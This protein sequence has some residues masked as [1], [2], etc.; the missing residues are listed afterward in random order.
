MEESTD[1]EWRPISG[2]A[3][4]Y[5]VSDLGRVRSL[6]RKYIR[7]GVRAMA[8]D[9]AGYLSLLLY[10]DNSVPRMMLVHR[11]VALAFIGPCP[12]GQQV[13]HRDGNRLNP[14][15][16]NLMYGT[17]AENTFDSIGHGTHANAAKTHCAQ[18][19]EFTEENIY[20]SPGHPTVRTCRTCSRNNSARRYQRVKAE[21]AGR[22][23]P[24]NERYQ[25]V[26]V[27]GAVDGP[28]TRSTA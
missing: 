20:R 2:F 24:T 5:E 10:D 17:K 1:E 11:L 9:G 13:R 25:G 3:E 18:G 26:R 16:S 19:H 28:A 22:K 4:R 21:L 7:G 23:D 15:L 6:R 8:I 12:E 14:V 27:P